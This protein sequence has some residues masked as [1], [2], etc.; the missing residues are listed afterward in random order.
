M[1][2]CKGNTSVTKRLCFRCHSW[3]ILSVCS[4]TFCHLEHACLH[5]ECVSLSNA[6]TSKCR[7]QENVKA[8]QVESD[9][10][11]CTNKKMT[12]LIRFFSLRGKLGFRGNAEREIRFGLIWQVFLKGMLV[13][14]TALLFIYLFTHS[15]LLLFLFFLKQDFDWILSSSWQP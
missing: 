9:T 1:V 8:L 7:T 13:M 12:N 3:I 11:G 14:Y 2:T 4:I 10:Y 6:Q 5:Y 15:L